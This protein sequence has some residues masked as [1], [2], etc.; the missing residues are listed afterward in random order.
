MFVFQRTAKNRN[1]SSTKAKSNNIEEDHSSGFVILHV[2]NTFAIWYN[3]KMICMSLRMLTH[4]YNNNK[5]LVEMNLV[6]DSRSL[7]FCC[8]LS[9]LVHK[10]TLNDSFRAPLS[11]CLQCHKM[12]DSM[13]M[14]VSVFLCICFHDASVKWNVCSVFFSVN[15]DH[16]VEFKCFKR[17]EWKHANDKYEKILL[18]AIRDM[19]NK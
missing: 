19:R 7:A 14:W 5:E 4:N 1:L 15:R 9:H 18:R 3:M 10:Q 2:W 12:Y 13:S 11:N 16:H 17:S 6:H 8:S